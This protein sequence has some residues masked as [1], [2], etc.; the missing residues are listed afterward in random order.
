MFLTYFWFT[1]IG[2]FSPT[3]PYLAT[4]WLYYLTMEPVRSMMPKN[5]ICVEQDWLLEICMK[6]FNKD[7]AC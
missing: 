5:R 7:S 3:P 1:F 2:D 4:T 6:S